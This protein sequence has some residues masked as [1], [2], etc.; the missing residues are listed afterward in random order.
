MKMSFMTVAP[1][2]PAER[3]LHKMHKQRRPLADHLSNRRRVR[4]AAAEAFRLTGC[5]VPESSSGDGPGTLNTGQV[6]AVL[7]RANL[8]DVVVAFTAP[9]RGGVSLSNRRHE[10]RQVA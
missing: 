8:R 4:A 10:E 2:T 3:A 9:C 1:R 5:A 6:L 7:P